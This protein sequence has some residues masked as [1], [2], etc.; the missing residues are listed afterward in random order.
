[1][2]NTP[3]EAHL[4]LAKTALFS[5]DAAG[6]LLTAPMAAQLI[7]DS[8]AK[9]CDQLRAEVERL[10]GETARIGKNGAE[11]YIRAERAEAEV[12]RLKS[13]GAASAFVNMSCRASRAE[14][15]LA[16]E[17]A[18][19]D[20]LEDHGWVTGEPCDRAAIDAAMKADAK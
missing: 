3:T 15:E 13:D 9:A 11:E 1:M 20:W 16:A 14:V 2:S 4:E 19:L 17:R 6:R 5:R 10:R 18:R 12:E 7:A 8:E